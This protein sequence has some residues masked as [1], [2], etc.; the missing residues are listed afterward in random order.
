MLA[1][2]L[3]HNLFKLAKNKISA[4]TV[5]KFLEI[6]D[7]GM[8]FKFIKEMLLNEEISSLLNIRYGPII[9]NAA[10]FYLTIQQRKSIQTLL[11]RKLYMNDVEDK[12]KKSNSQ[13][14]NVVRVINILERGC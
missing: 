7:G 10:V 3:C 6:V 9:L 2:S 8:K 4:I 12:G 5:T 13:I 11:L 1:K 14:M